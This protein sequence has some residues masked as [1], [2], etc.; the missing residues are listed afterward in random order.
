MTTTHHARHAVPALRPIRDGFWRVTAA[1]GAVLGYVE[2]HLD[3][4]RRRYVARRLHSG[5]RILEVGEFGGLEEAVECL[6]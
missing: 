6:R 3:D 1:S 2:E 5:I 4:G